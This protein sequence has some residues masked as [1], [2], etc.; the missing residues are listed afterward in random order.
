MGKCLVPDCQRHLKSVDGIFCA[1]FYSV[2]GPFAPCK[3]AW[4][5]G[6]FVPLGNKKFKVRSLIDEDGEI[7]DEHLE[8]QR[9]MTG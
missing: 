4:C 3:S 6:C 1:K 7:L 2:R 8:D 9:L 5:G